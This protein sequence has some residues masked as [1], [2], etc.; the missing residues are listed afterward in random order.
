MFVFTPQGGDAID[1]PQG[2]TP[3]DFAYPHPQRRGQQVS[4]G[5]K[6]NRRIV[7]LDTKLQ[8][9]DIVE[10]ITSASSKGPSMDWLK[11]VKTTEAKSK[12]RAYLKAS[13]RDEN[14]LVGRDMVEKE[15]RR[16]NLDPAKL[17]K[18][19]YLKK[20]CSANRASKRRTT[21]MLPSALA[22]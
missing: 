8:T 3:L 11:I 16:Q 15:A 19:E 17:L 12:I 21:S 10:I 13:L 6:V 1:L 2:S 20:N 14:I 9:G 18:P 5:A 22:G 4:V 7:T